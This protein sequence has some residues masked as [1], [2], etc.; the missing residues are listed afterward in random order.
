MKIMRNK[1]IQTSIWFAFTAI[2]A[3]FPAT[4]T[5]TDW[6][7]RTIENCEKRHGCIISMLAVNMRGDTIA[8][9]NSTYSM[10]PASVTKTVTTALALK[11]LGPDFRFE[12]S[13]AY[14][15]HIDSTGILHGDIYIVGGADPTLA[16]TLSGQDSV[17][18]IWHRAVKA[19][20][21]DSIAGSVIGDDR[22]FPDEAAAGSW[23]LGD[24]GTYYGSGASGLS[25]H[26]N[27]ISL[28]ITP[29]EHPE[30]RPDIEQL[31]PRTPWMEIENLAVTGR[32][33]SGNSLYM[34][35]SEIEPVSQLRG[36]YPIDGGTSIEKCSNKYPAMTC[37]YH[38][39]K[40]L[41]SHGINSAFGA[42]DTR[43]FTTRAAY[44]FQDR[45]SLTYIVTTYSAPLSY[46]VSKTNKES[47][48]LYAETLFKM[49]GKAVSGSAT[50]DAS[51]KA[52]EKLLKGMGLE[53]AGY[54]QVEAKPHVP[55]IP[56]QVPENDGKGPI[57]K[58]VHRIP[59]GSGKG[60]HLEI[61]PARNRQGTV[62][63]DKSQKRLHVRSKMLC[64][65]HS[66]GHSG[67]HDSL[68]N[69][70]Q[71]QCREKFK[72]TGHPG[73][74]HGTAARAMKKHPSPTAI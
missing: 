47:N 6:F 36:S 17:F 61:C 58:N 23:E 11:E 71:Q 64:G 72:C 70:V 28:R 68:R 2:I 24:L 35:A 43:R 20:G 50:Y 52:A 21:I 62:I 56:L 65:L 29:S 27:Y 59:P 13:I 42:M 4:A 14:S 5:D 12:T 34:L 54:K 9:R 19:A 38:F 1:F 30:G 15:G 41:G 67:R 51:C 3:A 40:Y 37:A 39:D 16:S 33:K 32:R 74:S 73:D 10:I 57:R 49:T 63:E 46:I 25:F 53:T 31:F 55:R 26:E 8:Q 48:N 22:F 18:N 60:R 66:R 7:S 69:N 44:G 45:D